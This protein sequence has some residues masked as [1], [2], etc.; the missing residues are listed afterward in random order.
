MYEQTQT[1]HFMYGNLSKYVEI[2]PIKHSSEDP[3]RSGIVGVEKSLIGYAVGHKPHSQEEEE[4][5]HILH[6]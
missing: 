4:E 2:R 6:L 5:E 1:I 3:I